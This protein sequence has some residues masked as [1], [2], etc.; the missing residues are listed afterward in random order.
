MK[1]TIILLRGVMPTGKNKV[2]MA[3]LRTALEEVGLSQVRTYA[4]ERQRDRVDA[5]G[6]ARRGAAGA[7]D[8]QEQLGAELKVLA[9]HV[10]YFEEVL[11]RNPFRTRIRPSCISRCWR[12]ARSGDAGRVPGAGSCAG[13]GAGGGRHG[14]CAL[15]HQ[16]QRREGQQQFHREKL[17]LAAT[18][19]N[20]N[21]ISKLVALG[22]EGDG[23]A[24]ACPRLASARAERQGRRDRGALVPTPGLEAHGQL[25]LPGLLPVAAAEL[26]VVADAHRGVPRDRHLG[27]QAQ[28]RRVA[29]DGHAVTELLPPSSAS[30]WRGFRSPEAWRQ[31]ADA[32]RRLLRSAPNSHAP[33]RPSVLLATSLVLADPLSA[34]LPPDS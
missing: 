15:P 32:V 13:S 23:L 3:P 9:R 28:H 27:A 16:V 4:T 25:Q 6:P 22:N 5:A 24:G 7:R 29:R 17:K 19:R 1:T 10:P 14:L 11:A 18:T 26:R 2:L 8:D 12:P 30:S 33:R 34:A 21:T 20:F 31:P